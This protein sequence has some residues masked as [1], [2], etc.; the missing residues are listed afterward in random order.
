GA[1][2]FN[3]TSGS[4]VM[5]GGVSSVQVLL[6]P[7]DDATVELSEYVSLRLAAGEHYTIG[8]PAAAVGTITSAEFGGDFG[9][10]PV[11]YPVTVAENGAQ[12]GAFGPTLGA[13]RDSES[14]GSHAAGANG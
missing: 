10:P 12:H 14:N 13:L 11:P 5:P 1:L 8:S 4:I 7:I 2:S 3:G 9:D 6:T